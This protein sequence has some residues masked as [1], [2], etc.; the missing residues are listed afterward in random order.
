MFGGIV[1]LGL[2]CFYRKK[3]EQAF[4]VEDHNMIRLSMLDLW[5]GSGGGRTPHF[6]ICVWKV[7]ADSDLMLDDDPRLTPSASSGGSWLERTL[8]SWSSLAGSFQR[9]KSSA[10]LL[11]SQGERYNLYVRMG[12]SDNEVQ[13]TRVVG[14]PVLRQDTEVFFSQV[15]QM[16]FESDAWGSPLYITVRDQHILGSSELGRIILSPPVIQDYLDHARQLGSKLGEDIATAQLRGMMQDQPDW[17][18]MREHLGFE[19]LRL[20]QG[21]AIVVAIAPLDDAGGLGWFA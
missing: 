9:I 21:G 16:N 1:L 8:P 18:Y 14:G 11:P 20:S 15:L 6:Q 10:F 17:T 2:L 4:G 12:Y 7:V 5:S 13:Q 3:I 19:S